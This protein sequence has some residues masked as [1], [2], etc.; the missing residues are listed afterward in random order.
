MPI[1]G[2]LP[3]RESA[4]IKADSNALLF[5]FGSSAAGIFFY[6]A[7]GRHKLCLPVNKR[8]N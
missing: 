6:A 4:V 8:K 3:L 1:L 7:C 2:T 5:W